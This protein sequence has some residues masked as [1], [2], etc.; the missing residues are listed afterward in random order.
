M[1]HTITWR[2][3]PPDDSGVLM[4]N[5]TDVEPG[6]STYRIKIKSY[7]LDGSLRKNEKLKKSCKLFPE[8]TDL[9]RDLSMSVP[10][11]LKLRQVPHSP[12]TPLIQKSVCLSKLIISHF[13]KDELTSSGMLSLSVHWPFVSIELWPSTL[14]FAILLW[15]DAPFW[16][17]WVFP[18]ELPIFDPE[19]SSVKGTFVQ[20]NNFSWASTWWRQLKNCIKQINLEVDELVWSP[21]RIYSFLFSSCHSLN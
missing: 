1:K 18:W 13:G 8:I 12:K 15:P 2:I 3:F 16:R 10:L 19:I 4:R 6:P 7:C 17:S 14:R 9:Q 20:G 5:G 11:S 21:E